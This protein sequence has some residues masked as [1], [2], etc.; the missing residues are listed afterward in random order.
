MALLGGSLVTL[1]IMV[2][3]GLQAVRILLFW[4]I[5]SSSEEQLRLERR[6][7][8]ISTL[9]N[10]AL[11]FQV[12]SAVLFVF[13]ADDIHRLFVGAMCATGSLNA[14]LVGWL[15]LLLKGFLLFA[16]GL[17]VLLNHLD[18]STED[19]PPDSP[20]VCCAAGADPAGR[21]RSV[22][23]VALLFRFATGR[24]HLLLRLPVQ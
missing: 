4:D 13:T 15:V 1:L 22:F 11:G 10:Y 3:A 24:D 21:S 6:T 12:F 8:L 18:Q 7:W 23:A 5:T 9:V 17:W 16:A 14:N 19:L 2:G 20:Q